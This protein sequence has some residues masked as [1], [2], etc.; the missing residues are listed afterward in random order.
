VAGAGLTV[1]A[2][3]LEATLAARLVATSWYRVP[4]LA[5][6][7]PVIVRVVVADPEIPFTSDRF[8]KLV[9]PLVETCHRYVG[10]GDPLAT[11]VNVAVPP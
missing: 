10:A 9:P 2:T 4:V 8:E 6:V 7:A 5:T 11:A 3:A 1:S